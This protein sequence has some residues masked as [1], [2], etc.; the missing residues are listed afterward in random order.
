[1]VKVTQKSLPTLFRT[2]GRRPVGDGL[3]FRV[4]EPGRRAYWTLKYS[5][6]GKPGETSLGPYP[7]MSLAAAK[8]KAHDLRSQTQGTV[9][10]D[11]LAAKRAR[12]AAKLASGRWR[13]PRRGGG[14]SAVSR[15]ITSP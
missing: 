12:R 14:S 1:M 3:C 13:T 2:K 5:V 11:P 15:M 10:I 6:D 7:E 4:V 9:K 8:A